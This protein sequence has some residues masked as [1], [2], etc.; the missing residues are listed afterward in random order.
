MVAPLNSCVIIPGFAG[1]TL[2]Y[3]GG[4]GGRTVYWYNPAALAANL[5]LAG[6]LANDGVSP[7][8]IAGKKLNTLGP[9]DLGI[10][11]PLISGLG[12]AGLNPAFWAYDWRLSPLS[13]A[14]S[15]ATWLATAPLTDPFSLVCHSMGGILAQLAY[16]LY[17]AAKNPRTWKNTVYL[18]T[19]HGGSYWAAAAL[20]GNYGLGGQL[21]Y[22]GRALGVLAGA[23][24]P[25]A[26][27]AL[28][29]TEVALGQLTGS[30]P[31][32]YCLLPSDDVPWFADDPASG[33]LL[34]KATYQNTPGGQQ[35]Q[36]FD[37]AGQVQLAISQGL[38]GV[39]ATEWCINGAG[40]ETPVEY[41]APGNPGDFGSYATTLDGDGTVTLHRA[42][43]PTALSNDVFEGVAHNAL[44]G[45]QYTVERVV[46]RL[47]DDT[48]GSSTFTV[49]LP[50]P[51]T[52]PGPTPPPLVPR[53][54][55]QEINLKF[56][57]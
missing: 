14:T 56:D 47:S 49:E 15:L 41:L 30:W 51:S 18:G 2:T 54:F 12:N 42:A 31:A 5:P 3:Q 32:L 39:R 17:K 16:P 11:E 19:P 37:L 28:K 13:L 45:N 40:F 9:V 24:N 33:A 38:N 53:V 43:L 35:Q 25:L 46:R 34:V 50:R 36:W 29:A 55:S 52:M 44:P 48:A 21:A 7:Y 6:A 4:F 27:V 8:P 26:N 57:P 23:A 20:S 1:S 10:Y 22:L